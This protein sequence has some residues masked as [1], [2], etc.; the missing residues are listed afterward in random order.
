MIAGDVFQHRRPAVDELV[1]FRRF[2]ELV[3][4]VGISVYAIAGNHDVRGPNVPATIEVFPSELVDVYTKPAVVTL[5]SYDVGPGVALGLLPWAHPGTIR[6]AVEGADS[7]LLADVILRVAAELFEA[8]SKVDDAIPVLVTHHALDGTRLPTGAAIRDVLRSSEVILDT[9]ALLEQGWTF[10]LAGHV[11]ADGLAAE[12]AGAEAYSVGV[13]WR[14]DFG[15]A[16]LEPGFLILDT[17]RDSIEKVELPDRE[18]VTL[19][20]T[21]GD[22]FMYVPKEVKGAI[23]RVRV[24]AGR[25]DVVDSTTIR[26]ELLEAGA[27]EVKVVVEVERVERARVEGAVDELEPLQAIDAWITAA[28]VGLDEDGAVA[29]RELT[30]TLLEAIR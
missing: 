8:A 15:E 24:A 18:L 2:L 28:G 30:K 5:P 16:N 26:R 14:N 27:S 11:H 13:P 1:T 20:Q 19:E 3:R 23:V 25:D 29:L 12:R 7:E 17:A 6:A 22:A 4:D 9:G 10:V 21:A